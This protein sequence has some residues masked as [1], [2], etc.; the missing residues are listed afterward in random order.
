MPNFI[1]IEE[2]F[3]GRTCVCTD[4]QTNG[5]LRPTLL[6]RL[7]RIDLKNYTIN[8]WPW[9]GVHITCLQRMWEDLPVHIFLPTNLQWLVIIVTYHTRTHSTR[10]RHRILHGDASM[11]SGSARTGSYHK[12]CCADFVS[13]C[14]WY[15]ACTELLRGPRRSAGTDSAA[16]WLYG[17]GSTAARCPASG[18]PEIR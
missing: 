13:S 10:A 7:R 5:H 4:W 6:G 8:L 1:E 3:C 12:S 17:L 2:T 11:E 15:A 18:R 16:S 9:V 14:R